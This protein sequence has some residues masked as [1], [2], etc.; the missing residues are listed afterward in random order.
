[1]HHILI[2]LLAAAPAGPG[3]PSS[4]APLS[5]APAARS[6]ETVLVRGVQPGPRLWRVEAPSVDGKP[7]HVLWILATLSP[8]PRQMAWQP[9]EVEAIVAD[10]GTVLAPP[11][12]TA[13]L[14]AGGMFKVATL[15][16]A[17]MKSV[18]N[19]DGATLAD[20]LPPELHARWVAAKQA[21]GITD[22]KIDALKPTLAAIELHARAVEHA[23]LAS[24]DVQATVLAAATR[25]RVPIEQT[26]LTFKL[27]IDR[28]R[29]KGGIREFAGL[30]PDI[31]CFRDTLDQLDGQL[32]AMRLRAN[33]WARGDLEVL[34]R[35][36]AG[37]LQ[38]PCRTIERQALAFMQR[39]ELEGEVAA[40]WVRSAQ[41]ALAAHPVSLAVLPVE[42]VVGDARYLPR[43]RA[44]GYTVHEPD[45]PEPGDD[46]DAPPSGS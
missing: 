43:L 9:A 7:G 6:L 29:L 35:V 36:A 37:D 25:H 21:H 26:G 23:G 1:M 19:A 17:A 44:L 5:S 28:G 18:K 42:Q 39:P 34:R 38:S 3:V 10:A 15:V 31:A 32:A 24:R 33:A 46:A 12:A 14:G 40:G 13:K 4:P 27:E 16:P 30:A 41:A 2:A 20:V 22:R 45:A 11:R 8:L